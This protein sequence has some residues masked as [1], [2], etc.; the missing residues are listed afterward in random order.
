M[1]VDVVAAAVL[2]WWKLSM[3]LETSTSQRRTRVVYKADTAATNN[4]IP[5]NIF[6]NLIPES[7]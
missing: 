4:L 6:K 7:T 1:Q 5:L 2:T 3:T